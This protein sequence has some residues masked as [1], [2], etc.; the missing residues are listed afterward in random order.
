MDKIGQTPLLWAAANGH[1]DIVEY[2]IAEGAELNK[3]TNTPGYADH[4]K[5]ALDWANEREHTNAARLLTKEGAT[6]NYKP[7]AFVSSLQTIFHLFSSTPEENEKS[8]AIQGTPEENE[9]HE[10]KRLRAPQQP[11]ALL[12]ENPV[13]TQTLFNSKQKKPQVQ[14]LPITQEDREWARSADWSEMPIR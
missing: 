4:E 3:A 6:S 13:N 9:I 12:I 5:T 11:E 1:A 10:V 7:N 2:L 14:R 8:D